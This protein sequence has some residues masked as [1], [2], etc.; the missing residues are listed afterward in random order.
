VKYPEGSGGNSSTYTWIKKSS[1]EE[2]SHRSNDIAVSQNY[3][4]HNT[5]L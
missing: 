2:A 5:L 4:A 3:K 1:K